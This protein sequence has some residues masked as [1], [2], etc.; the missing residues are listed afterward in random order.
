MSFFIIASSP[1]QIIAAYQTSCSL[2]ALGEVNIQLVTS[3][4]LSKDQVK[5]FDLVSDKAENETELHA[6]DIFFKIPK[7]KPKV[8]NNKTYK[9][10]PEIKE[11]E[12]GI[13][14]YVIGSNNKALYESISRRVTGEGW[15]KMENLKRML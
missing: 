2:K 5:K 7:K 4:K 14:L 1:A 10:L 12:E 3:L 15:V 11:S 6:G 8:Y 13:S 9:T